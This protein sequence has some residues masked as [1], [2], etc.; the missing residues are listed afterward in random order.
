MQIKAQGLNL[1]V[2]MCSI[3]YMEYLYFHLT[4]L[5]LLLKVHTRLHV[6]ALSD[7]HQALL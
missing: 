6:S 1:F 2:P 3:L 7:H 5:L 4:R